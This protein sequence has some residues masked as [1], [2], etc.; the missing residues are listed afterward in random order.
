MSAGLLHPHAYFRFVHRRV[1]VIN[2]L[3]TMPI[4]IVLRRQEFLLG[5]P[6]VLQSFL[7]VRMRLW[8]RDWR[9]SC[10]NRSYRRHGCCRRFRP[11]CR[12]KR[13]G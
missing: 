1:Q 6:H 5:R 9:R 8:R 2:R 10:W 7:D 13:E 3:H 12:R 4:E 11:G